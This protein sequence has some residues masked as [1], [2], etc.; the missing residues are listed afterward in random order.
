MGEPLPSWT[1]GT[2]CDTGDDIMGCPCVSK[3]VDNH[4]VS[5]TCDLAADKI[6]LCE[7]CGGT[8]VNALAKPCDC[9][10]SD[11]NSKDI[12]FKPDVR[13]EDLP[14][15]AS[16]RSTVRE[17]MKRA[18]EAARS[19]D[20]AT[21]AVTCAT[22]SSPINMVVAPPLHC[23]K[24]DGAFSAEQVGGSCFP[25]CAED[26]ET[27][28]ANEGDKNTSVVEGERGCASTA[29]VGERTMRY[30]SSLLSLLIKAY[31]KRGRPLPAL[32]ACVAC[33]TGDAPSISA[34]GNLVQSPAWEAWVQ[35]VSSTS[36]HPRNCEFSDGLP[37]LQRQVLTLFQIAKER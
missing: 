36:S 30:T 23:Q 8:G 17:A 19:S 22:A 7:M 34:D 6:V 10:S 3:E 15:T 18:A 35:K 5:E 31:A 11:F 29:S 28:G 27:I 4:V 14:T 25:T 24:S 26:S 32:C 20:N 12:A 13:I 9:I 16:R 21:D 37:R 1:C 2:C 33:P